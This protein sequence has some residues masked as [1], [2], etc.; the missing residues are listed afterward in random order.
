MTTKELIAILRSL[1]CDKCPNKVVCHNMVTTVPCML[2]E[3]SADALEALAAELEAERHR[4]DRYVDFELAEAKELASVKAER[5]AAFEMLR[6]NGCDY[7]KYENLSSDAFP[8]CMCI[9][10]GGSNSEW[11]FPGVKSYG[12]EV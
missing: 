4:H 2:F 9:N 1:D 7:C 12:A 6:S 3:Q 8:C 11:E 5:D 10:A